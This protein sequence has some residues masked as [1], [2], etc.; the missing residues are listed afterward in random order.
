ME[1]IKAVPALNSPTSE[2]LFWKKK[3][4]IS[5]MLCVLVFFIHISTLELYPQSGTAIADVNGFLKVFLKTGI[6]R[7]AVP[8]FLILSGIAFFKNY[9]NKKY[10]QKLKARL[11]SLVVPYLLWNTV[12]ILFG[13]ICSYT[14]ISSF[15]IGRE[16]VVLSFQNILSGIFLYKY[17]LP[18]WFIFDLIIFAVLAPVINWLISNKYI[19]VA[20]IVAV[21]V[22]MNFDLG[23]PAYAFFNPDVILYYL[24]GAYI[25]KHCF[26]ICAK[27]SSLTLQVVSIVYFV[28]YLCFQQFVLIKEYDL[29]AVAE[30]VSV[31]LCAFAVWCIFDLFIDKIKNRK[32]YKSSFAVYAMHINVSAV[33]TK[34][35][36]FVLPKSAVFAMVNFSLTVVVTLLLIYAFCVVL[37]RF[38]PG[39]YYVLMGRKA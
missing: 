31:I 15:M 36:Y 11:H 34:L 23:Y 19:G 4:I 2:S 16:K 35:L 14:F 26:N 12:W 18:F 38:L 7:Y 6:T 13:I 22:L 10:P 8:M 33:V 21:I 24:I 39:V 25:G 29:P 37:A 17:N 27:K 32:I 3:D 1:E 20:V 9:S 28:I 5:Y 30:A